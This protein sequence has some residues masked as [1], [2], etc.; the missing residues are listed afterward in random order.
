MCW[1]SFILPGLV[2][3]VHVEDVFKLSDK[4]DQATGALAKKLA[5]GIPREMMLGLSAF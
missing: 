2:K 4:P 3:K 5:H 1:Q